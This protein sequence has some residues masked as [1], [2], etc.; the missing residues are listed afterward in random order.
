MT[1]EKYKLYAGFDVVIGQ[2]NIKADIDYSS[3]M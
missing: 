2:F 3:N 1:K